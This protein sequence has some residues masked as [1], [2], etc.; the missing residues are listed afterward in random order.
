MSVGCS[1]GCKECDGCDTGSVGGAN[2]NTK[3]RCGSGKKSTINNPLHRTFNREAL[4][5]SDADWTKFN[6]WRAPGSAPVF[7]ACGRAGGAAHPTPGHGEYIDTVN[8]KFGDNG[9][10]VLPRQPT[11]AV[12]KA[13]SSVETMWSIRAN[14]GGGYQYRLCPLEKFNALANSTS[15]RPLE[16][17]FQDT[18]MD[19][20]ANSS[21]MMSNGTMLNLTSTFVTD[22]TLPVGGTWQMVPI[23]MTRDQISHKLGYPFPPPCYDP[24]PPESLGQGIC[25]GEWIVNITMYD[26][27]RVP[28]HLAPGEYVLGFRW[29]CEA[30]AQVGNV[31]IGW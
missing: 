24:T 31:A 26:Q 9:S 27:L 18:P 1:I 29:D 21:M 28:A 2:P 19:F 3:D 14:H 6:P 20:A 22:G 13:G 23:P 30:S 12:W 11:G 25:S 16:D 7:D 4:A 10:Q 17:C 15:F 5:G 8:A